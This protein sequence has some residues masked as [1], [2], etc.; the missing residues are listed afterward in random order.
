MRV[1]RE[2]TSLEIAYNEALSKLSEKLT[3]KVGIVNQ[4]TYLSRISAA[5]PERQA[6]EKKAYIEAVNRKEA[7]NLEII[8]KAK[9]HN[10][11][12]FINII[13]KTKSNEQ[14]KFLFLLREKTISRIKL[15]KE[16]LAMIK[17][18]PE[19]IRARREELYADYQK[20]QG[21]IEA[22]EQIIF[23]LSERLLREEG[24][25]VYNGRGVS[26]SSLNQ[27]KELVG[28][29]GKFKIREYINE[30]DSVDIDEES[31]E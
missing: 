28:L 9:A 12:P 13:E 14:L 10:K 25:R 22:Q 29:A 1:K 30:E 26:K 3:E 5:L 7:I 20:V 16:N 4:N 19:N 27:A 31:Y 17:K 2:L 6:R 11:I 15:I 8:E 23:E 18:A 24:K 21:E